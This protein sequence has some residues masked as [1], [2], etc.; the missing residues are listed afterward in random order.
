VQIRDEWLVIN[1]KEYGELAEL[2]QRIGDKP[3]RGYHHYYEL[4][5]QKGVALDLRI[6]I[7]EYDREIFDT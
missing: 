4:E 6:S 7:G 2:F 1:Q 3:G 5:S